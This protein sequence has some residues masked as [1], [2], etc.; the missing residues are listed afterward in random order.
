MSAA[1]PAL[2]GALEGL[3][4]QMRLAG[5]FCSRVNSAIL[6]THPPVASLRTQGGRGVGGEGLT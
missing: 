4:A 2:M 5:V 3:T 1:Y 6:L